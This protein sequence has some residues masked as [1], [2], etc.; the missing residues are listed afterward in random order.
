[1][2]VPKRGP[3]AS[4]APPCSKRA[5]EPGGRKQ[6]DFADAERNDPVPYAVIERMLDR[7]TLPESAVIAGLGSGKGRP[8][9]L[10]AQRKGTRSS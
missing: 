9:C 6:I 8:V 2:P 10:A 3:N 1:M 7:L 5:G 4:S